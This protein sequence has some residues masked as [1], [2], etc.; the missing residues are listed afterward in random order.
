MSLLAALR[1]GVTFVSVV[2]R[3]LTGMEEHDPSIRAEFEG[4]EGRR[5]ALAA[6][7]AAPSARG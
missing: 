4:S 6:A 3:G 1:V 5:A 7:G 2:V